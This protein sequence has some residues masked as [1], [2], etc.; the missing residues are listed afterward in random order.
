MDF[1]AK[2]AAYV[3]AVVN[4]LNLAA[5]STRLAALQGA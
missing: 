4:D 2:A 5:A 1:G 3:D